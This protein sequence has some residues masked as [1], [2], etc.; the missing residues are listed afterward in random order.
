MEISDFSTVRARNHDSYILY[1][2]CPA[3]MLCYVYVVECRRG[4]GEGGGVRGKGGAKGV[5]VWGRGVS[6][7]GVGG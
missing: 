7:S 5:G 3:Y 2:L 4:R 1:I 6:G